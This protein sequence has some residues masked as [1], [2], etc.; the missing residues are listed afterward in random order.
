MAVTNYF[1]ELG[2]DVEE[3]RDLPRDKATAK[4]Q[5]AYDDKINAI[6]ALGG[7]NPRK[8]LLDIA[9]ETL[10]DP[11]TRKNH[12]KNLGYEFP[13][14]PAQREPEARQ[15]TA[16]ESGRRTPVPR[17]PEPQPWTPHESG[18]RTPAPQETGPWWSGALLAM[19]AGILY[20][21]A[22]GLTLDR[23]PSSSIIETAVVII[24]AVTAY[25]VGVAWYKIVLIGPFFLGALI[26]VTRFTAGGFVRDM[27]SWNVPPETGILAVLGAVGLLAGLA[28]QMRSTRDFTG[29][30][31]GTTTVR[32]FLTAMVLIPAIGLMTPARG[33]EG[34]ITTPPPPAGRLNASPRPARRPS[35]GLAGTTGGRSRGG[36]GRPD[37]TA[38]PSTD[39]SGR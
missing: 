21:G 37:T 22:A 36:W 17:E 13:E 26:W 35:C 31:L 33:D 12:A 23:T 5:E 20:I 14:D 29:E 28:G 38:A 2:L 19:P 15:W 1:H 11:D 32:F 16:H 18:R 7:V 8:D 6:N 3:I 4:V 9:L 30:Y 24:A 39:W 25:L 34:P 27:T 10:L